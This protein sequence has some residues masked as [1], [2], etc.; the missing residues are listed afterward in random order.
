MV[1]AMAKMM[2]DQSR[3]EGRTQPSLLHIIQRHRDILFDSIR[4]FDKCKVNNHLCLQLIT[5]Q[6]TIKNSQEQ[7]ELLGSIQRDIRF[8]PLLLWRLNHF[9]NF[10]V[11]TRRPSPTNTIIKS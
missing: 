4:E 11:N 7:V 2:E 5:S 10:L 6:A 1:D 8:L 9:C 3:S